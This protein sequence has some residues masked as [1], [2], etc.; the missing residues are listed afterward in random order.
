[1]TNEIQ[2][3]ELAAFMGS[4]RALPIDAYDY[5]HRLHPSDLNGYNYM[6]HFEPAFLSTSSFIVQ[7]VQIMGKNQLSPYYRLMQII[8]GTGTPTID[9]LAA[10]YN[11]DC[12]KHY[13]TQYDFIDKIERLYPHESFQFPAIKVPLNVRAAGFQIDN[14]SQHQREMQNRHIKTLLPNLTRMVTALRILC[15]ENHLTFSLRPAPFFRNS[16]YKRLMEFPSDHKVAM[17]IYTGQSA[18]MAQEA[19][20]NLGPLKLLFNDGGM[21]PMESFWWWH[22]RSASAMI[23]D[24]TNPGNAIILTPKAMHPAVYLQPLTEMT[25]YLQSPTPTCLFQDQISYV[26]QLIS[27]ADEY[28]HITSMPHGVILG[29][30]MALVA[31]YVS[32]FIATIPTGSGKYRISWIASPINVELIRFLYRYQEFINQS[33]IHYGIKV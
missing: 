1:M 26:T 10:A 3:R 11:E 33:L 17:G 7:L 19:L 32:L 29:H 6:A 12:E 9:A 5:F 16:L 14:L 23:W 25:I 30:L 20:K 18:A 21:S 27:P 4:E 15:D 13:Q 8:K 24:N 28:K 22:Y 2:R 31:I